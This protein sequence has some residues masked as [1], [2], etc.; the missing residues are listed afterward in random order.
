MDIRLNW[1]SIILFL[2][3]IN[4]FAQIDTTLKEFWPLELG[5]TWQYHNENGEISSYLQVVAEDTLLPNN[6][7]YAIIGV[8]PTFS[9]GFS[10]ERI[11][12][13]LRVQWGRP[14]DTCTQVI[15][16][17]GGTA[18]T[19]LSIYH[20][21]D[22]V[23]NIWQDC[24]NWN[25]FLGPPFI[26]YAGIQMKSIFGQMQET[27]VFQFG[28]Y[29][30]DVNDILFVVE[31][32]VVR[33]IGM[34]RR[35]FWW[36]GGYELLTGAIIDGVQYGTI[37]SIDGSPENIPTKIEL[38]Q[39]YPNP[40]NPVTTIR[41]DIPVNTHVSLKVFNLLGQEVAVLTDWR[42]S[43]GSYEITFDASHLSSGFYI[44][45]LQTAEVKRSRRMLLVQ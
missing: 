6:F 19:E 27:I 41:Y 18:P 8:P 29:D 11:D 31:D 32:W 44:Y 43:P 5:D 36:S 20:L 45:V 16:S 40:F 35:E 2:I 7:R 34:Y 38:R 1:V 21:G 25:G 12:S 4:I 23:G 37:V 3:S 26:R 14:C 24:I 30:S 22:T 28:Y 33:G 13:L 42:Q 15:D 10:Y 39:N 9:T 17:C